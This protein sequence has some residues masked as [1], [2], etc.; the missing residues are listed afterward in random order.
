M[1]LPPPPRM[2]PELKYSTQPPTCRAVCEYGADGAV[3]VTIPPVV[4]RP[5]GKIILAASVLGLL[6]S[7]SLLACEYF[8]ASSGS[9]LSFLALVVGSVSI[10][11][12]S[13]TLWMGFRWTIVQADAAG[14]SLELRGLL[15]TRRRFWPRGEIT[16][17]R[18]A[19]S[20]YVLGPGGVR[21]GKIDATDPREERW[22]MAVLGR[23]LNVPIHA[24]L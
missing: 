9:I 5:I 2:T 18:K 4:H 1:S 7:A 3:R 16:G 14:L 23:A 21:L 11:T 12:L 15:G 10:A 17:L 13:I 8:A 24:A 22:L 20:L 19:V 6:L